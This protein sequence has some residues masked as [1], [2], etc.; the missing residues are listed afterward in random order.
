MT[1]SINEIIKAIDD[2]TVDETNEYIDDVYNGVR[3]KTPVRSGRAKAGWEKRHIQK[4]GDEGGVANDVEYIRYLE[5]GTVHM[6]PRNMV[7]STL[8]ELGN[9]K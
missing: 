4:L 8:Q 3:N 6:A 7:K 1:N 9:R 2:W 5:D